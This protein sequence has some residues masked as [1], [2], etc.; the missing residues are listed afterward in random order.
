MA[1]NKG[2][3]GD[4]TPIYFYAKIPKWLGAAIREESKK[5]YCQISYLAGKYLRA[6]YEVAQQEKQAKTT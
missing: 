5:D 4:E 1:K 3:V 2:K 6:G